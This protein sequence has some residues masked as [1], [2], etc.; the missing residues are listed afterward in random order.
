MASGTCWLLSLWASLLSP[1]RGRMCAVHL[2][3]WQER[4][5]AAPEPPSSLLCS[6]SGPSAR[7][8][9]SKSELI[10]RALFPSSAA[11]LTTRNP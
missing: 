11:P 3:L 1:T 2:L 6:Q 7:L 8:P 10:T 4:C 9:I 5:S